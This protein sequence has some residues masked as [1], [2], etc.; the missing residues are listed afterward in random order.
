MSDLN[1]NLA[2][3]QA[4]P[5]LAI[6]SA[7]SRRSSTKQSRFS[8]ALHWYSV[9][10]MTMAALFVLVRSFIDTPQ[11]RVLPL[12][13]HQQAGLFVL[14]FL[15]LRLAARARYGWVDHS[16]GMAPMLKLAA[17]LAHLV[18]YA[19]LLILPVL[20]WAMCNSHGVTVKFMGLIPLPALVAADPDLADT[21]TDCHVILAWSMLGLIVM[22]VAAAL[23]HHYIRR[24]GVLNAMIP[25]SSTS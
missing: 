9:T 1:P 24:D 20:G 14:L 17:A 21:L 15:V 7:P 13:L 6:P 11:L 18:M 19:C 8:I 4:F 3:V 25:D 12:E 5:D 16:A 2:G 22:H 23:W 10:A